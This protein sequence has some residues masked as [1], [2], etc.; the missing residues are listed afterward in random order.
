[1]VAGNAFVVGD[2]FN[3]VE[4]AAGGVVSVNEQAAGP[5][6]VGSGRLVVGRRGC[7]LKVIRDRDYFKLGLGQVAEKLRKLGLHR[8]E[9]AAIGL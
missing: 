9:V 6:A 1:M 2:V 8:R 7:L 5:A 3:G 4:V